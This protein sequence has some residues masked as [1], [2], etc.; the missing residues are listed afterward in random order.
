MNFNGD[1][2]TGINADCKR[3]KGENYNY[4]IR[5]F[6]RK[7]EFDPM[8]FEK[9]YQLLNRI[10]ISDIKIDFMHLLN[11]LIDKKDRNA[12]QHEM[13]SKYIR[14]NNTNAIHLADSL[15]LKDILE[16]MA[17]VTFRTTWQ[18]AQRLLLDNVEFVHDTELQNMDKEDALIVFEDHI[19]QLEKE[20]EEEMESQRKYIRRAYRKN[21]EAFLVGDF[22]VRAN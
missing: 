11:F 1:W 2:Y 16:N 4:C 9:F 20:H 19:R 21:R 14:K 17:K 12:L 7:R 10:C 13:I 8:M 6:T 3:E 5:H 22:I 15:P 18:E